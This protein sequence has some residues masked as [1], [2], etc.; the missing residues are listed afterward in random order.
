MLRATIVNMIQSSHQKT[1]AEAKLCDRE[2]GHGKAVGMPRVAHL[3]KGCDNETWAV[4][5]TADSLE[6]HWL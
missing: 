1:V 4:G 6:V 3:A 2:I 5:F